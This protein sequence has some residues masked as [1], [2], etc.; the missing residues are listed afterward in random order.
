MVFNAQAC[1][2]GRKKIIFVECLQ[3]IGYSYTLDLLIRHQMFTE[4]LLFAWHCTR[5]YSDS[6]YLVMSKKAAQHSSQHDQSR[7]VPTS[8]SSPLSQLNCGSWTSS[9]RSLVFTGEGFHTQVPQT[10]CLKQ[11]FIDSQFQRTEVQDFGRIDFL[12]GLWVS[13]SCLS[14]DFWWFTV[15]LWCFLG[16]RILT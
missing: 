2:Q 13:D 16:Y 4:G 11:K 3:Y 8:S 14:P 5:C 7:A 1:W 6:T 12:W 15:H 9:F 10:G